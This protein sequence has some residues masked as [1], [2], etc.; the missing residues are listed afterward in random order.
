MQQVI[1]DNKIIVRIILVVV[2]FLISLSLAGFCVV[3]GGLSGGRTPVFFFL[4]GALFFAGFLPAWF[5]RK[6]FKVKAASSS[7][8][9]EKIKKEK[10]LLKAIIL[11]LIVYIICLFLIN[12]TASFFGIKGAIM[13]NGHPVMR[14]IGNLL[15][16]VAALIISRGFYYKKAL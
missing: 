3:A 8:E 9:K 11:F 1:S 13:V 7:E 5:Y 4:I 15:S 6:I 14:I 2:S 10:K 12:L 16:F